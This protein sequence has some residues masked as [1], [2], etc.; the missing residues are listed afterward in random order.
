MGALMLGALDQSGLTKRRKMPAGFWRVMLGFFVIMLMFAASFPVQPLSG[1][2]NY[3]TFYC[4]NE[5]LL[6]PRGD[7]HGRCTG[8]VYSVSEIPQPQ[9]WSEPFTSAPQGVPVAHWA[10]ANG[11]PYEG[12]APSSSAISLNVTGGALTWTNNDASRTKGVYNFT[13][14]KALDQPL[15]AYDLVINI[16]VAKGSA[17]TSSAPLYLTITAL[18]PNMIPIVVLRFNT[19]GTRF[20]GNASA[21]GGAVVALESFYNTACTLTVSS[22]GYGAQALLSQNASQKLAFES[23]T[24]VKYLSLNYFINETAY[25]NYDLSYAVK[26]E[27]I[28][29]APAAAAAAIVNAPAGEWWYTLHDGQTAAWTV[30]P[31]NGSGTLD[32][33]NLPAAFNGEFTSATT[34]AWK[35]QGL[36]VFSVSGGRLN[37]KGTGT[38]LMNNG[39]GQPSSAF[40]GAYYA[41]PAQGEGDF[42]AAVR[43]DL[44]GWTT[45]PS[46]AVRIGV[47]ITGASG[48]VMAY[49]TASFYNPKMSST[50]N[51]QD[52]YYGV[53]PNAAEGGTL[54]RGGRSSLTVNISR[55]GS[56]W[57]IYCPETETNYTATGSTAAIGGILLHHTNTENS[58][59]GGW[60]Y[61]RT[62]LPAEIGILS[63]N[64]YQRAARTGTFYANTTITYTATDSGM[65]LLV[66]TTRQDSEGLRFA[67]V[68]GGDVVTLF[69]SEGSPVYN[70]T[71]PEG[72]TGII[73]TGVQ[74]PLTGTALVTSSN[75]RPTAQYSGVIYSGDM[76]ALTCGDQGACSLLKASTGGNWSGVLITG[77]QQGWKVVSTSGGSDAVLYAGHTGQVLVSLPTEIDAISVFRPTAAVHT[78]LQQGAKYVLES[79]LNLPDLTTTDTIFYEVSTTGY[80]YRVEVQL[81][82]VERQ[83]SGTIGVLNKMAFTFRIYEDGGLMRESVPVVMIG[84]RGT[85]IPVFKTGAYTFA[86]LIPTGSQS[87]TVKFR[88]PSSGIVLE[89]R[90]VLDL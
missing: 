79:A 68:S 33:A 54:L 42:Y 22:G 29:L 2:K 71:V 80:R 7:A 88:D 30:P 74:L 3:V 70:A 62:N 72:A 60:D 40:P 9:G 15:Y 1:L 52:R 34:G 50:V 58:M 46:Y 31:G 37:T 32:L 75:S 63:G 48:N 27:S 82:S 36:S 55:T 19:S 26:V 56:V 24:P 87:L 10:S 25:P 61:V 53:Q 90:L 78:T 76:L 59:N 57:N 67:G 84:E 13:L 8:M 47:A 35:P 44:S 14:L 16:Y 39:L 6:A 17:R 12:T 43:V 4:G 73:V 38:E 81:L 69:G 64:A 11:Y 23:L 45:S 21:Y 28:S 86:A 66:S 77:L 65:P 89:G 5:V 18:D 41:L 85:M 20:N 83:T 49:L 51:L